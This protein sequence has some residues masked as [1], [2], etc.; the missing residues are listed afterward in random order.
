MHIAGK[1]NGPADALLRMHQLEDKENM[2]KTTALIP[3]D[4]FLNI[5]QPG[6]LGTLEHE[7]MEAQQQHQKELEEWT[8][9]MPIEGEKGPTGE[10]V[11]TDAR[12]R[13]VVPPED[14][15]KRK[16]MKQ[17]HDHWGAGHP[18]RDEMT[19]C[20]QRDYFW[21]SMRVWIA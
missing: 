7:V 2:E 6:D 11:W 12:G 3:E 18:G 16:I 9:R 21:P 14:K 8:T 4:V 19:Q 1:M 10:V 13:F 17:L 15:V 20:I 5:F